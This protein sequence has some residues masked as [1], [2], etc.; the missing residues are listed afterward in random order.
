L[1][2]QLL[3][4]VCFLPPDIHDIVQSNAEAFL[5]LRSRGSKQVWENGPEGQD[6]ITDRS[7]IR[8]MI[9]YVMQDIID[10]ID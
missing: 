7:Q 9:L 4:Y 10:E 3:R 8:V 1:I 5:L 6:G 2:Q